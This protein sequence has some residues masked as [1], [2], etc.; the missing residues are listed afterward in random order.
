[1]LLRFFGYFYLH[2]TKADCMLNN[3]LQIEIVGP[4]GYKLKWVLIVLVALIAIFIFIRKMPSLASIIKPSDLRFRVKKNKIYHPSALYF[5]IENR[6]EKATVIQ[7]PI[8]R[9]KKGSNTKAYKIKAVNAS[10]I[11][12][13]FL[14]KGAK[15]QLSVALQP[16][17]DFSPGL[18]KYNQ[19]RVECSFDNSKMK[20]SR[21]MIIFPT[22][23]KKHK[24]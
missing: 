10:K 21:Y 23:F 5:E 11:Y 3:I 17:Y 13:L 4:E 20:K 18:K 16:F 19:I 2:T 24:L 12:P 15:H 6:G 22:L 7:H 14:E 8:I 9:F 1:M